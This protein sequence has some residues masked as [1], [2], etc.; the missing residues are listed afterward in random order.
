M[1]SVRSVTTVSL[2][3]LKDCINELPLESW[4]P[5]KKSRLRRRGYT[6]R[7]LFLAY[8]LKLRENIPLDTVLSRKLEEN[9]TYREFCGFRR[10][11]VPSHDTFSRFFRKLST[12]RLERLFSRLDSLLAAANV[13]DRDNMAI[14]ATEVLSNSRNKHDPDPEAGYGYKSDKERF[15]GYWVVTVAG[16]VSEIPRA[17]KDTSANVHQSKTT[18]HLFDRLERIDR[19]NAAVL[20][21]DAAYDD[22]KTH[23]RCVELGLVPVIDYNRKRS[24]IKDFKSL[25]LSNWRKRCLGKEGVALRG[26]VYHHRV[27]VER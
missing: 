5:R 13:F 27:A 21:A 11:E 7:A 15:H 17:V 3:L 10:N 8:L 16:T 1:V 18:L 25:R 20:A 4:L 23:V 19:R 2:Q 14:D 6:S 12:G 24:E 26:T 22:K 9:V